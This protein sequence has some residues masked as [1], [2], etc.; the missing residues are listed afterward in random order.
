MIGRRGVLAAAGG[1][2]AALALPGCAPSTGAT[3]QGTT[4]L[5]FWSW[6]P[7]IERNV[8]LWN[9]LHPGVRVELEKV[10]ASGGAQY[11]KMHAALKAGSPPD[12]AQVEYQMVPGFLLDQGLVDLAR[13]GADRYRARFA[14]W[15][16][17]QT[18]YAGG[19]YAIP[20]DSGPMVLFQRQDLLDRWGIET[21]ATWDDFAAAARVVRRRGAHLTSFSPSNPG[22]FT[23]LAWQAGARWFRAGGDTWLVSVDDEPTRRVTRYWDRL[24][25][26]RLVTTQ[27]MMQSAWYAGLQSGD[28]VSWTGGSWGD[29]LLTGNAPGGAGKWRVRPMPQWHTPGSGAAP[30]S[31]NWGG[32][33]TAVFTGTRNPRAA[34]DFAVWLNSDPASVRLLIR[35]GYGY[36]APVSGFT[37]AELDNRAAYFGGQDYGAVVAASG[38]A[39]DRAWTWGP[40]MDTFFQ[41]LTDA[42]SGAVSDGTPLTATLPG[43]QARTLADLR[44]KG[45]KAEAA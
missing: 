26:D 43:L 40:T 6:V 17:Q 21:P 37:P 29:A 4:T 16:W 42:L 5:T 39:V 10:A 34:L 30:S 14:D 3:G 19:V 23:A 35:G 15:L 31:G 22:W 1:T 27:P 41:R 36:P 24:I 32:S 20:Q 9:R 13:H 45:L 12:L 44:D 28:L 8:A 33:T 2:A 7:G 18:V 25:K 38:A 11:A